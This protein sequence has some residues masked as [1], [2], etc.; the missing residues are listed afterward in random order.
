MLSKGYFICRGYYGDKSDTI[1]VE[2]DILEMGARLG[3]RK[4]ESMH[5]EKLSDIDITKI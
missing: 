4:G 3:R 5:A 1:E 2:E